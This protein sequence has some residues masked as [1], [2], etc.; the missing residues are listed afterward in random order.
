MDL[1]IKILIMK[2]SLSLYPF[3]WKR[4]TIYFNI[5]ECREAL[6]PSGRDHSSII[7]KNIQLILTKEIL[8]STFYSNL[9]PLITRNMNENC[10]MSAQHL[11][12]LLMT[13]HTHLATHHGNYHTPNRESTN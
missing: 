6:I 1:E 9:G 10:A 13:S 2:M 11:K 3:Q 12:M 7:F 5:T 8:H 4:I